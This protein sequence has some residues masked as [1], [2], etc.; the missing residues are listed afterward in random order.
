[1]YVGPEKTVRHSAH[2]FMCNPNEDV[3]AS[4]V[5]RGECV[6]SRL[7]SCDCIGLGSS[8]AAGVAVR[9][10][11]SS[12]GLSS[13]GLNRLPWPIKKF[14]LG[15]VCPT[16]VSGGDSAE[17]DVEEVGDD[18]APAVDCGA[19][20]FMGGEATFMPRSAITSSG[21]SVRGAP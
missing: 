4:G 8:A 17:G 6:C 2:V 11:S 14:M 21:E 10:V 19:G 12:C 5:V 15:G 13:C 20:A 3:C 1:M 18:T 16:C 9:P 7:H